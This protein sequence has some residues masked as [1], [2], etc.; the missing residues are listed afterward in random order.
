VAAP[1]TESIQVH[2][3]KHTSKKRRID[4]AGTV[5]VTSTTTSTVA[6]SATSSGN[7]NGAES[8]KGKASDRKQQTRFQRV[9]A[10]EVVY[11]DDRLKSNSF[12]AKACPIH[13]K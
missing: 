7:V 13:L 5:V 11:F 3:T 9:K 10:D 8:Q 4:E 6:A 2:V 1:V 12:H